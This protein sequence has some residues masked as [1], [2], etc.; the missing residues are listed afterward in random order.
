MRM[1]HTDT[2]TT[3]ALIFALVLA[4]HSSWLLQLQVVVVSAVLHRSCAPAV[5]LSDYVAH[6]A[7]T[8]DA[9]M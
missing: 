6:S 9:Y 5:L 3:S 2:C 4:C 7:G 8:V 1:L